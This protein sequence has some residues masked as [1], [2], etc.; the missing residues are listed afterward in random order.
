MLTMKNQLLVDGLGMNLSLNQLNLAYV[1]S[2]NFH[3]MNRKRV[4]ILS[5]LF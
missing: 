4:L 2:E 3:G 5:T 1:D